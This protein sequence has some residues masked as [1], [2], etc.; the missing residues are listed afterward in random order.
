MAQNTS[1]M[2]L[3]TGA[4]GLVGSHVA[5]ELLKRG[6]GVRALVRPESDRSVL[7]SIFAHYDCENLFEQIEWAEGD[8]LDAESIREAMSGVDTV[9]NAAAMVSFAP[10]ELDQMWRVN[11]MGTANV[12]NA[13]M[14][15]GAR[16]CH[17]SSIATIGSSEDGPRT[18]ESPWQASDD[19]HTYG[20]SKFRQE[21]EVWRGIEG[22][23]K[24]VI[25]APGVVVGPCP[26]WR[27]S[28]QIVGTTRRGM[29][30]YTQG[31]S[32]YIDARDL[33]YAMVELTD[34]EAWGEK[35]IVVGENLT[36]RTVQNL[37][38]EAFG[39]RPPRWMARRRM[40]NAVATLS[41]IV[42]TIT[43]TRP[44]LTRESVRAICG[45][46]DAPD[47][48]SDKLLKTINITFRPIA[49]SVANTV[50]FHKNQK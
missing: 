5:L 4:T 3:L 48:S 27:S 22:G 21:M 26:E 1:P 11:V 35:F 12:V 50:N 23:L 9:Y 37:F 41:E 49:E 47:L 43:R 24:A 28:G 29:P 10:R 33:A 6:R 16:L 36:V 39:T 20:E 25:V 18:E 17:V 42:S 38:A 46:D 40:L 34:R 2:N 19:R 15:V 14:E 30:F 7:R 45:T 13:A 31:K 44:S 32:G 8:V